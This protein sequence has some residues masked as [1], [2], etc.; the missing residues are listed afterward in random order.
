MIKTTIVILLMLCL[1]QRSF[2]RTQH[3]LYDSEA[4]MAQLQKR[5]SRYSDDLAKLRD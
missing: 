2:S 1:I 3:P 4:N 5:F